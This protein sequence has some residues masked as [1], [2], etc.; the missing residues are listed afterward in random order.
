MDA[1]LI[2]LYHRHVAAA[3]DRQARLGEFLEHEVVGEG[4]NYTIS[5]ATLTFGDTVT[6]EA[7]DLGSHADP[8]NSWLW[9][10]C[11]PHLK[12]TP[13][14]RAL[15]EALRQLGRE[16]GIA[17]FGAD[18]QISCTEHL[19][20]VISEESAHAFAA[21]VA[22][23]LGFDAY[24]TMPF[25]YGRNAVL[26]R[27]ARLKFTEPNPALRIASIF[28]RVLGQWSILDHRA[29]LVGYAAWYGLTSEG[30]P[31]TV[32]LLSASKEV[33]TATFDDQNRLTELKGT[34]GPA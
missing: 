31:P 26:I 1:T 12:L 3:Y 21:I 23:E 24:Y 32:R 17:A 33:L 27:D 22:G 6:V 29:A 34:F 4:W 13:P 14:N 11:H 18:R 20:E 16:R 9:S 5:T 10:W 7:L 2:A 19:G 15:G 28:P 30:T 8:D 25:T